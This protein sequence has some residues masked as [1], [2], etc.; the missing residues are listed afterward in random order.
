ML[1]EFV[2]IEVA[3][4]LIPVVAKLKIMGKGGGRRGTV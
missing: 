3:E 2:Q 4:V 1:V